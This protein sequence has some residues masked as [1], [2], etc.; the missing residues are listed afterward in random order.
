MARKEDFDRAVPLPPG[1]TLVSIRNAV[2]YM[3]RWQ[4][5]NVTGCYTFTPL[6]QFEEAPCD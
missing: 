1:L 2:D 5:L 6:F 3:E 4:W